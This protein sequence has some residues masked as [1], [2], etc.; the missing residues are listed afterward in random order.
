MVEIRHLRYFVAVAE[1]LHFGRAA[2][3]LGMAQ[4]P[5][6]QQIR[7]LEQELGVQLLHRTKR[8]VQLTE[9][10]RAFLEEAR[11][12]IAQVGTAVAVAQRAGRGEVGRLAIG[13]LGAATFSLLPAILKVFR[14]RF[15]GVEIE[16]HELKA[17]E[18]VQALHQG[19]IHV[20]LVRLPVQ[21]ELL[22]LEPILEEKLVVAL[23]EQHPLA[24]RPR[25]AFRDLAGEAFLLPPRQLAPGFYEQLADLAQQAGFTLRIG[26]E[27]SQLQTIL[28]LVAA[29]MGITLVPESV[30][31]MSGRGVVFKRLPEPSPT[32]E[33]AVAWRRDDPS[34]VLQAFLEVVR[35]TA[36][37]N[38]TVK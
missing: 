15:P 17:F 37:K 7:R 10:G 25:L 18:L 34:Q 30:M 24:E 29:G 16:L 31:Q 35:E 33:I 19:R 14:Q 27:A 3:K 21:D 22:S 4:P 5:L 6:S 13:F 32:M 36:Q 28:N 26:A 38:V 9:P 20:G 1:E 12:V 8:R 2:Q 23:P 11:K